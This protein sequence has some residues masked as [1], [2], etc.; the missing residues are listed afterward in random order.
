MWNG[1]RDW[2]VN[3]PYVKPEC[4]MLKAKSNKVRVKENIDSRKRSTHTLTT[5]LSPI[6]FLCVLSILPDIARLESI[7]TSS[8]SCRLR[9]AGR[10]IRGAPLVS[11]ARV[12]VARLHLFHRSARST[13]I[14][15]LHFNL[16]IVEMG[17]WRDW[18]RKKKEEDDEKETENVDSRNTSPLTSHFAR[19]VKGGSLKRELY[20]A[21]C[22]NK[23]FTTR[24]SYMKS[25]MK[26][27]LLWYKETDAV[28]DDSRHSQWS[29][30]FCERCSLSLRKSPFRN[31]IPF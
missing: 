3:P 29:R 19:T 10:P 7:A 14:C 2:A 8:V 18:W 21:Q 28:N 12:D 1:K 6:F 22:L 31:L 16:N 15:R 13:I 27:V 9:V 24:L 5:R 30:R 17:K 25:W 11:I 20:H 23:A 26:C 4:D